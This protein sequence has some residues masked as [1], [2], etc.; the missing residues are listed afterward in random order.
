MKRDQ[1]LVSNFISALSQ[2][3][4]APLTIVR[5]PDEENRQSPAVEV[6]ASDSTGKTLAIEHTLIQPFEGERI[7]TDRFI[8]VFGGLEDCDD[9]KKPGCN[10]DVIVRVGSIPTGV[11]WD[12]VAGQVREHLKRRVP[13]LGEGSTVERIAGLPVE[14]SVTLLI[15]AHGSEE[16]DHVWISRFGSLASLKEVVRTALKRK[17]PKLLAENAD[18]RMLLLEQADIAHGH[19]AVRV[20]VDE[21]ITDFPDLTRVDEIW[22]AITTCWETEDTLF[23]NALWPNVMG[24]KLKL[25]LRTSMTSVLGA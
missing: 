20:A 8:R 25:D 1:R 23:F 19:G 12:Y 6:V 24:T 4:G 9:L 11:R 18:R 7:D 13:I 5:R 15:Q 16:A 21:L 3:Y 22:L 2:Q 10:V 14:L 17:L